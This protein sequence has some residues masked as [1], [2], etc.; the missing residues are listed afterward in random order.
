MVGSAEHVL[1]MYVAHSP[2]SSVL[3]RGVYC[4]GPWFLVGGGGPS[5]P[6]FLEA[7]LVASGK[8]T[9]GP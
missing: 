9:G 2:F 3:I 8:L 5:G 1:L 4:S 7:A 6:C